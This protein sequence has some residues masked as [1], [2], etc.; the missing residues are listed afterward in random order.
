VLLEEPEV[1][2][3][4]LLPP[5]E[6]ALPWL[7]LGKVELLGA[8]LMLELAPLLRE[9]PELEPELYWSLVPP[10]SALL[11]PTSATAAAIAR[12]VIFIRY[13]S[14]VFD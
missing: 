8:L 11:H 13:D 9:L 5:G 12:N 4:E 6:L 14:F 3:P 10:W 7:V 1:A 2:A